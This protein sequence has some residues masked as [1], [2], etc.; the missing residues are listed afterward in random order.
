[1]AFSEANL[2]SFVRVG[3]PVSWTAPNQLSGGRPGA[4][5]SSHYVQ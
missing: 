4:E 5:A 2:K 3:E 1:M